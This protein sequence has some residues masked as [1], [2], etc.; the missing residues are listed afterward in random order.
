[1]CKIGNH[2]RSSKLYVLANNHNTV[3]K[4]RFLENVFLHLGVDVLLMIVF[5]LYSDL[6]KICVA[7]ACAVGISKM[8]LTFTW[9]GR[10]A[11]NQ[12]TSATSPAVRGSNPA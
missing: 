1:M 12:I 9:A 3:N 5:L 6:L 10:E 11:T 4:C 8:S 7:L 2:Q